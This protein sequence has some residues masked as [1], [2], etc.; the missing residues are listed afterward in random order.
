[1]FA[2]DLKPKCAGY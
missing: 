2:P 1:M